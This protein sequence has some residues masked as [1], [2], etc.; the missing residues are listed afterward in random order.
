MNTRE[1]LAKPCGSLRID[2]DSLEKLLP[3]RQEAE[4]P[5]P[6]FTEYIGEEA[7]HLKGGDSREIPCDAKMTLVCIGPERAPMHELTSQRV[8]L[9]KRGPCG[10]VAT[11]ITGINGGQAAGEPV[12]DPGAFLAEQGLESN[13]VPE[14]LLETISEEGLDQ[15]V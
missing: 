13:H 5:R 10:L 2:V 14:H 7:D 12:G 1:E 11:F 3:T 15:V 8:Q 6:L 4:P 9:G